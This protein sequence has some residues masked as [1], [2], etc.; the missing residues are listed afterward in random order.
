MDHLLPNKNTPNMLDVCL[1]S[2]LNFVVVSRSPP[3]FSRELQKNPGAGRKQAGL[4]WDGTELRSGRS[5]RYMFEFQCDTDD[6]LDM[7]QILRAFVTAYSD[8]CV[9]VKM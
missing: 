5:S 2:K 7:L 6:K 3:S 8:M 4:S 9:F 1:R